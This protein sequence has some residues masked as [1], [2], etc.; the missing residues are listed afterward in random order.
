M[1]KKGVLREDRGVSETVGFIIIFG[2]VMAGIGLVTLYGY[3]A[4]LQQQSAANIRNMEKSLIVL[5]TDINGLAYKNVPYQETAIQVADG[6]LVLLDSD[7]SYDKRFTIYNGTE[8]VVTDFRPGEIRYI[9][10]NENVIVAIQNGAIVKW[11]GGGSIGSTMLAKPRWYYDLET[12]TLVVNLIRVSSSTSLA[13][14]GI[15]MIQMKL[16]ESNPPIPPQDLL[17]ATVQIKY[18]DTSGDYRIA[19]KNYF[20]EFNPAATTIVNIPDVNKLVIKEYT[21]TVLSL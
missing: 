6:T 17:G 4:L 18:E 10:S 16:S 21:I 9:S 11:Q 7:L 2:I 20:Q 15:G 8:Y 12:K 3:P 14:T 1:T 5:Q 13:Q 19:W